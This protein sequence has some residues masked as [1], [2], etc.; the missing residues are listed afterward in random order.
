MTTIN[1]IAEELVAR[2]QAAYPTLETRATEG[3]SA[4]GHQLFIT[5]P[6][7]DYHTTARK[8]DFTLEAWLLLGGGV[9]DDTVRALR[10][11]AEAGGLK[12]ALEGDD[13]T[14]GGLVDDCV[15]TS[16][17]ALGADEYSMVEMWGG[18]FTVSISGRTS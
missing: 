4:Y 17:R 5:T 2:A 1:D 11:Y 14:L 8:K 18:I 13:R 16:F 6:S 9:T 10:G 7:F 15:V 12:A 3:G